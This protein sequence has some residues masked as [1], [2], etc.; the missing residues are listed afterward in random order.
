MIERPAARYGRDRL[1]AGR[2]RLI[3]IALTIATLV[4]GVVIA[5]I[6][7]Q[8]F[9]STGVQAELGGYRLIDGET[10]EVTIN[11]TRENPAE[12]VVCILRARSIDGDETGR[13]EVLVGP[14]SESTVQ[15]TDIVKTTKPPVTGDV[16]G[17]GTQVPSYLHQK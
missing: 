10:V 17:C 13:R 14:S 7:F 9:D 8:R 12:P 3:A 15:V 11:V 16:Y 6:A 5:V 1:T 4:A 2:R